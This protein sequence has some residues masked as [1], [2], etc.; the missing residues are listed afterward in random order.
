MNAALQYAFKGSLIGDAI[1][2]PVHWYY[3]TNALD[4]DYPGLNGFAKP[5]S[6]HTDSILWRSRYEPL[7]EDANILHD[8]AK[9]WGKRNVHYHQ[10]LKAGENTLNLKLAAELYRFVVGRGKYDA[11]AWLSHYVACMLTPGWHGDTYIEEYHRAF[12]SNRAKGLALRECG[13]DD[14]HIGG[15]A[16]VPALVAAL[17]EIGTYDEQTVLEHIGL[18][19]RNPDV[20]AGAAAL[21]HMLLAIAQGS[22]VRQAISDHAADWG[23]APIFEALS[24][25]TDRVIVGRM[26]SPACYMPD[27]FAAALALAWKYHDDFRRGVLAN[28]LCGGDNCHRGVVV[29]AL[30]GA[31]NPLPEDWKEQLHVETN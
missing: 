30:L 8:Q 10:F 25:K 23:G 6:V 5:H 14:R 19:H 3:D 9:Y 29:G 15:L 24:Q 21:T 7:N 12:F 1:S 13:I 2:M 18:T 28:A 17:D 11:D 27:S 26:L 20:I 16:A 31:A 22:S 4:R